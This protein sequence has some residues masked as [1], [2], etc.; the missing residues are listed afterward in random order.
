MIQRI[1]S[2]YLIMATI[3]S[4]IFLNGSIMKFVDGVNNA[5]IIN[6]TGICRI[7]NETGSQQVE[8]LIP[9][10]GLLIL[11][12]SLSFSTI[13]LHRKRKTQ[14]RFAIG[15]IIFVVVLIIFLLYYSF[16]VSSTF[17]SKIVPGINL[18]LPVFMLVCSYLAY[19]G[20][21]KDDLLVKSYD[22]LR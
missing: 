3:I 22:R 14:L 11:I 6:F 19:K 7:V 16:Y 13:F 5:L 18:F 10:S 12:P 1:Q 21:R 9:L 4:V 15:L 8:K 2:L 17:N 20:I